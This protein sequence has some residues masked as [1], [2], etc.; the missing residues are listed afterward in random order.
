MVSPFAGLHTL[1]Y[2]FTSTEYLARPATVPSYRTFMHSY[3]YQVH[4]SSSTVVLRRTVS[5]RP[6]SHNLIAL[7]RKYLGTQSRAIKGNTT[8]AVPTVDTRGLSILLL[9]QVVFYASRARLPHFGCTPDNGAVLPWFMP[10][11]SSAIFVPAS[12]PAR[13]PFCGRHSSN[14]VQLNLHQSVLVH[15]LAPTSRPLVTSAQYDFTTRRPTIQG[16]EAGRALYGGR[17]A[18]SPAQQI[19]QPAVVQEGRVLRNAQA[20]RELAHDVRGPS[21][22]S[23]SAT[24]TAQV[25]RMQK[26]QAAR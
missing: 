12:I 8:T 1:Q 23:R 19:P 13:P 25:Y 7:K 20:S 17:T 10:K 18:N 15:I 26:T 9:I 21:R 5:C 16:K 4:S 3:T 14:K 11:G 2:Y 24:D 22:C 6:H